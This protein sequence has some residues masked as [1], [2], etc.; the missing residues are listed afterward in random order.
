M[1]SRR[2]S[3]A[4]AGFAIITGAAAGCGTTAD[5]PAI[6]SAT[7]TTTSTTRSGPTDGPAITASA[8]AGVRGKGKVV[9]SA[10]LKVL[11]SGT[12]TVTWKANGGP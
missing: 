2:L 7:S 9:G 8:P 12:A 6:D 5:T 1:T 3:T 11:G 10:V 4:L